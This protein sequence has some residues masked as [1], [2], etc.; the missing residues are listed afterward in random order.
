MV[1]NMSTV[2]L[3]RNDSAADF[4]KAKIF[5]RLRESELGYST[6]AYGWVT[7]IKP[8]RI[9]GTRWAVTAAD[10]TRWAVTDWED[11]AGDPSWV[12]ESGSVEFTRIE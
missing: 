9:T 2:I 7:R 10:G 6:Q 12:K 3:L 5:F 4:N 8:T 11:N 1:F